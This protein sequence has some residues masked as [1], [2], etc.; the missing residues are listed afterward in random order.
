MKQGIILGLFLLISAGLADRAEATTACYTWD[1][2]E[3]TKVCSFDAS[4]STWT[5][6]LWRFR[7]DFGDGSGYT[8]TGSPT[9]THSYTSPYPTVQLTVI[10][11][12][13]SQAS[14][15]C[16]IIVFNNVGPPLP[17]YGDCP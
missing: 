10:P 1:C 5:G 17:T 2:N 11:L 16:Q 13:T 15:S 3:F 8:F 7:W 9:I 14:V 12:S 6:N 4:C